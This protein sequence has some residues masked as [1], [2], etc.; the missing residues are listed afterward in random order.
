M[1]QKIELAFIVDDDEI[2]VFGLKKMLSIHNICKNILIFSNGYEALKYIKPLLSSDTGLPDVI[3]LDINMPIMDG[4]QF[5]D[6][7]IKIKPSIQKKITIYMVSSSI[8]PADINKA[9]SY[10]EVSDYFVKPIR[11]NDLSKILEE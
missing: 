10:E 6:E 8:N 4:W 1:K 9:K 2:Y 11:L 5:L 7:F 3:L